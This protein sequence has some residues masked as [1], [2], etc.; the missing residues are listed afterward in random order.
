MTVGIGISA[1]TMT[2]EDDDPPKKE[3]SSVL[4]P[5]KS[6]EPDLEIVVG[7][8]KEV[9]HYHSAIMASYS[10][11]IDTMLASPMRESSTMKISFPD[12]SPTVWRKMMSFL[13]PGGTREV[14]IEDYG[15]ILPFFDKYNFKIGIDLCD[16]IYSDYFHLRKKGSIASWSMLV[17]MASQ[18]YEFGLPRSKAQAIEFAR[19]MF[20]RG[21]TYQMEANDFRSLIQL[22]QDE[23]ETLKS[24]MSL[25]YGEEEVSD[26]TLEEMKDIV[27]NGSFMSLF[28][29]KCMQIDELAEVLRQ[30][31]VKRLEIRSSGVDDINGE[32][33]REYA[34]DMMDKPGAMYY[35]YSMSVVRDEV[36]AKAILEALDPFGKKWQISI[37]PIGEAMEPQVYYTW[38]TDYGSLVPPKYGWVAD[39]EE[40]APLPSLSYYFDRY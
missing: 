14:K 35:L 4:R 22:I 21:T 38:K 28:R 23:E 16:E 40:Y 10:D 12:I 25:T 9:F 31:T 2:N 34:G 18:S 17:P 11:Y 29:T 19:D 36:P 37:T 27:N 20:D 5:L 24:I 6:C 26:K 3:P 7:S 39:S 32:Y 15:E 1:F 8:E 33:T 30:L 13:E